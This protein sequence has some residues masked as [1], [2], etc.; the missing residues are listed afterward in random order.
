MHIILNSIH[1]VNNNII[2]NVIGTSNA[3]RGLDIN[4]CV[5]YKAKLGLIRSPPMLCIFL[6]ANNLERF[7]QE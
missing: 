3:V 6:V 5:F 2:P 4:L 7:S 1:A